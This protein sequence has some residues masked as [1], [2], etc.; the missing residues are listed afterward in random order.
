MRSQPMYWQTVIAFFGM[1]GGLFL[2]AT[3]WAE[4]PWPAPTGPNPPMGQCV[5]QQGTCG[6]WDMLCHNRGSTGYED[7]S[8]FTCPN[9]SVYL[10]L[11]VFRAKN[12]GNCMGDSGPCVKWDNYPCV[13]Y[14]VYDAQCTWGGD[15]VCTWFAGWRG[16][17]DPDNPGGTSP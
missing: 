1:F 14:N 6:T 8:W 15:I 17:C 16:L 7:F 5:Q 3:C 11:K 10:S 9:T 12:W 13:Q 2:T 4:D